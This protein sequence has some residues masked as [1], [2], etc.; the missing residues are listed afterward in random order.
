MQIREALHQ[1]SL[2][3]ILRSSFVRDEFGDVPVRLEGAPVG[4]LV[5]HSGM[6][7]RDYSA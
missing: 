6:I 2:R 4:S 1:G 3:R 5:G 7:P